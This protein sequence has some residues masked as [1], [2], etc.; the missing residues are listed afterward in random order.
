MNHNRKNEQ[1]MKNLI[2]ILFCLL[3]FFIF[4]QEGWEIKISAKITAPNT[5]LVDSSC[6]I[7][8]F[9]FFNDVAISKAVYNF[10]PSVLSM[11][12]T[13]EFKASAYDLIY[14]KGEFM[15]HVFMT[16]NEKRILYGKVPLYNLNSI[17]EKVKV[18]VELLPLNQAFD[19]TK[20]N[21]DNFRIFP[22]LLYQDEGGKIYAAKLPKS[23]MFQG[24]ISKELVAEGTLHYVYKNG[25]LIYSGTAFDTKGVNLSD[26]IFPVNDIKGCQ[27]CCRGM[28]I[29]GIAPSPNEAYLIILTSCG[30]F[31]TNR[32]FNVI[33]KIPNFGNTILWSPNSDAFVVYS[34]YNSEG[35]IYDINLFEIGKFVSSAADTDELY[36]NYRYNNISNIY[37]LGSGI[38]YVFS[39]I[40]NKDELISSIYRFDIK[41]K[42][43]SKFTEIGKCTIYGF[44]VSEDK[45]SI[46][47]YD[48]DVFYMKN[49]VT[50]KLEEIQSI[51]GLHLFDGAR[52]LLSPNRERILIEERGDGADKKV[53]IINLKSR[54]KTYPQKGKGDVFNA[55]WVS[56]T[57]IS[58]FLTLDDS[59]TDIHGNKRINYRTFLYYDDFSTAGVRKVL[60]DPPFTGEFNDRK[61]MFWLK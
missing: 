30:A 47:F 51:T 41:T 24:E 1:D 39:E 17:S 8:S 49:I 50:N 32:Q 19:F 45:L 9:L 12:Y 4:S 52:I 23:R 2:V 44:L 3:P 28:D 36:N 21:K 31:F 33:K 14:A 59:E 10:I 35:V 60:N 38:Y 27:K 54:A 25:D 56:N 37:W 46:Y 40:N 20:F 6:Q 61:T 29:V 34:P 15:L 5:L 7:E 57:G 13:F 58:Y 53:T 42:K 48:P 55:E 22:T 16:K 26:I 18:P 11:D 43:A